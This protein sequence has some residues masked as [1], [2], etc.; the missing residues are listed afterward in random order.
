MSLDSEDLC[1][2]AVEQIMFVPSGVRIMM[3]VLA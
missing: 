2:M 3:Y 1:S